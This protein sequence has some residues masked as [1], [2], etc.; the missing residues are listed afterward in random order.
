[1]TTQEA[2]RFANRDKDSVESEEIERV[3]NPALYKGIM[4]LEIGTFVIGPTFTLAKLTDLP[5]ST[6]LAKVVA[7]HM[8]TV[9]C[10]GVVQCVRF[11]DP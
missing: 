8:E 2:L 5:S 9:N 1:M 3:L 10:H 6:E 4:G 7:N 11:I